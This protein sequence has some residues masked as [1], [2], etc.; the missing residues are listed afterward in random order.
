MSNLI[1][2]SRILLP[3][4]GATR[5]FY[6]E[7]GYGSSV[8]HSIYLFVIE[9]LLS[10]GVT[11]VFIPL[12]TGMEKITPA[13]PK[14]LR[15]IVKVVDFSSQAKQVD[16]LFWPI[17]E[18]LKVHAIFPQAPVYGFSLKHSQKPSEDLKNLIHECAKLR[19][20]LFHIVMGMQHDLAIEFDLSKAKETLSFLR[21]E[22]TSVNARSTLGFISGILNS[23]QPINIDSIGL[24]SS[25]STD[26]IN[27]FDNLLKDDEYIKM[28]NSAY[29][30]G[31][32]E[33]ASKAV[34]S[35]AKASSR[36]IKN[37]AFRKVL[38]YASKTIE[39]AFFVPSPESGVFDKLVGQRYFP[40]I[41]PLDTVR[42]CAQ[43]AWLKNPPPPIIHKNNLTDEI[44]SWGEHRLIES[45]IERHKTAEDNNK[46]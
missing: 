30:M 23:Y 44:I 35:L 42:V 16:T 7:S 5:D 10:L 40:P 25:A 36:L 8:D 38:K 2:Q 43:Q 3:E 34:K 26:F 39:L 14:L 17:F 29:E 18:E 27:I 6:F 24:S 12:G 41:F 31:I 11:Q 37:T 32:P 20:Q 19:L 45:N 46:S 4:V 21:S 15:S 28:A 33:R 22:I 13:L 9:E 1:N